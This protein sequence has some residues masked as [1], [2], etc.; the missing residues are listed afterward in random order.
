M[1]FCF[2]GDYD[3]YMQCFIAVLIIALFLFCIPVFLKKI[4]KHVYFVFFKREHVFGKLCAVL[5]D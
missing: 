4:F 5:T 1:P 2:L 3:Y